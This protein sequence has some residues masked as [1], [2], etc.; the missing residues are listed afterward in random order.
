[1]FEKHS[2]FIFCYI[3]SVS[4]ALNECLSVGNHFMV[5][6]VIP[7]MTGRV[8]IGRIYKKKIPK[9]KLHNLASN[10]YV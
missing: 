1:M 9:L 7:Y 6:T 3:V 10:I 5:C 8:M 4:T 2:S